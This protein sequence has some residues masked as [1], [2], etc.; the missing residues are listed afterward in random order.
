MHV[1]HTNKG[2]LP[3]GREGLELETRWL[4]GQDPSIPMSVLVQR[5]ELTVVSSFPAVDISQSQKERKR[6]V[7]LSENT[8]SCF[9]GTDQLSRSLTLGKKQAS[10]GFATFQP[11]HLTLRSFGCRSCRGWLSVG[12]FR[13]CPSLDTALHPW[14]AGVPEST[15]L[16]SEAYSAITGEVLPVLVP[17]GSLSW[18]ELLP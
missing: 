1:K 6:K 7:M 5:N 16:S 9:H 11:H 4:M 14:W 3:G 2:Q 8:E 13:C 18:L 15:A 12:S 10:V 17:L